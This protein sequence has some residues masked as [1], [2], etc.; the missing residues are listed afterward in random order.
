MDLGNQVVVVSGGAGLLG[1]AFCL[2]IAQAGGIPVIADIDREIGG[3]VRTEIA[4]ASGNIAIEFFPVDIT[5]RE[6]I[7][8]LIETLLEK[9]HRIDALVNSAYPRNKNYGR[10][11]FNVT[12][13]D[14]SEN[15]SLHLGGYFLMCQQFAQYFTS[16]GYG[17]IINIASIYGVIAPRFEIYEKTEM[18]MPVEYAAIKAGVIHLTKYFAKYLKGKSIRVNSISPGGMQRQQP[19]L[20]VEKYSRCCLNKGLLDAEGVC[21]S[22]LYLLS[23]HSRYVNGHN[24]VVDD[25]FTL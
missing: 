20:F 24:L 6:S 23:E 14:F 8:C 7:T 10:K 5:S 25:G 11:L 12:Y 21:G 9:Y 4:E 1:R 3:K 18:T 15:V 17:N 16:Q 13:A 2:S 19:S 22:L